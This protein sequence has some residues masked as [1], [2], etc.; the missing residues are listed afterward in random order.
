MRL[1]PGLPT[2]APAQRNSVVR[3]KSSSTVPASL[4]RVTCHRQPQTTASRPCVSE[5]QQVSVRC[6]PCSYAAVY[7]GHEGSAAVEFTLRELHRKLD[8]EITLAL[9]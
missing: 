6:W 7:D 8:A 3:T 2:S 9:R 1:R 4:P 5:Q